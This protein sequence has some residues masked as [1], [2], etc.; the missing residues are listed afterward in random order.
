VGL[1]AFVAPRP[2]NIYVLSLK[3][4]ELRK[5]ILVGV[6]LNRYTSTDQAFTYGRIGL[7]HTVDQT[8]STTGCAMGHLLQ[9]IYL[10]VCERKHSLTICGPKTFANGRAFIDGIYTEVVC[11]LDSSPTIMVALSSVLTSVHRC[12][13]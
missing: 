13:F 2:S 12:F 9:M 4:K 7:S 8:V 6:I 11:R 5:Y 10:T 3:R 1:V